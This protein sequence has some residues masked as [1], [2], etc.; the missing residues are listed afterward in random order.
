MPTLG[1]SFSSY[2]TVRFWVTKFKLG[3][4]RIEDAP[5][6]ETP[7][8]AVTPENINKVYDIV[9]Y[10]RA[11]EVHEPTEVVGVSIDMDCLL[12]NPKICLTQVF[13]RL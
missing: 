12:I 3:K 7:K 13:K 10:D 11:V 4:A 9:L 2:E 6:S 1:G 5:R 8:S